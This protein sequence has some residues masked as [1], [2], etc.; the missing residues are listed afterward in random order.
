MMY[1]EMLE[2]G[3]DAQSWLA[4]ENE[5]EEGGVKSVVTD[6]EE[7]STSQERR[8]QT[9]ACVTLA[10]FSGIRLPSCP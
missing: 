10:I 4:K 2:E 7:G 9:L 6:S 8:G 3:R 1:C 5:A